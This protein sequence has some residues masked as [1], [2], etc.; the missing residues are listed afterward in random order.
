MASKKH[1]VMARSASAK[2][3]GVK[4]SKGTLSFNGKPMMYVD[5][6]VADEIDKTD[7]LKGTGDVWVH[8]DPRRN[9]SERYKPDGV[10]SYFY[11][12]SKKYA[13]AWKD[14]EKRRKDKHAAKKSK[15]S[16][17]NHQKREEG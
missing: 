17:K 6:D 7:G 8:E 14:F 3:N 12:A 15:V 2:R 4:T 1:V 11:G 9:W 16:R 5:D 13:S 10:H